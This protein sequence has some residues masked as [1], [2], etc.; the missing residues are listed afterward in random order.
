MS[1][2]CTLTEERLSDFLDGTLPPEESAAFSEHGAGCGVCTLMVAEVGEMVGRMQ[3]TPFV[4][5]PPLL[6]TKILAATLGPRKQERAS[7]GFFGWLSA[8]WQPRFAMGVATV[9]ASFI[10]VVHA[11]G[12]KSNKNALNPVNV[13]RAANRQAH[14]TYAH[15]VKFVNDLRLVYEIQSRLASQPKLTPGPSG[16]PSSS[17]PRPGV[18]P[19]SRFSEPRQESRVVL[20]AGH[21]D[22]RGGSQLASVFAAGLSKEPSNAVPRSFL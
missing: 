15:G 16:G 18:E 6:L 19:Q 2:N 21:R 8:I 13:M 14:L 20:P 3:R 1:W 5:E 9:A 10:I 4:Q 7:E 22:T 11:G 12:T 17:E